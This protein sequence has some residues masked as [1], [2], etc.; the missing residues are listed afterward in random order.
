[1]PVIAPGT[2]DAGRADI[3]LPRKFR[4]R[5]SGGQL[6][7]HALALFLRQYQGPAG[8]SRARAEGKTFGRPSSVRLEAFADCEPPLKRA[9]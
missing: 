2:H 4:H 9:L 8:Q 6:L 7:R 5:R 3:Q 1:M